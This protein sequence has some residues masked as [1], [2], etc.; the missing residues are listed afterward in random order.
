MCGWCND[1]SNTGRSSKNCRY[2]VNII[3]VQSCDQSESPLVYPNILVNHLKISKYN[4]VQKLLVFWFQDNSILHDSFSANW[5]HF[6]LGTM[7]WHLSCCFY[8]G[9]GRCLAGGLK[10]ELS[11]VCRSNVSGTWYFTGCPGIATISLWYAHIQS[12]NLTITYSILYFME[13]IS[14]VV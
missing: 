6:A 3:A 14:A 5:I 10:S 13:Y 8:A 12:K 9:K 1:P 4:I 11:D 7:N 2:P